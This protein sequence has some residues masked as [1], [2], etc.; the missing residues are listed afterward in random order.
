MTFGW[1]SSSQDPRLG[2][3]GPTAPAKDAPLDLPME[4]PK[5]SKG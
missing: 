4:A 3:G 5:S 2:K 1:L